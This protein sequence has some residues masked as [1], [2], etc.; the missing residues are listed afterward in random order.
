M[1]HA[2]GVDCVGLVNF[3]DY[4]FRDNLSITLPDFMDII[5]QLRG[6][7]RATV[8]DIVDMRQLLVQKIGA[9]ERRLLYAIR[10]DEFEPEVIPAS[11]KDRLGAKSVASAECH[12]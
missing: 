7:N 3:I 12:E 9:L 2:V 10:G 1:V 6:A 4:I 11:P 8:R 5:L